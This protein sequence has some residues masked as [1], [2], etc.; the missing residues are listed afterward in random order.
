MR[1]HINVSSKQL[2]QV[3]TKIMNTPTLFINTVTC[4][5][6][7]IFLKGALSPQHFNSSMVL[8]LNSAPGNY[9][10]HSEAVT[11]RKPEQ[12]TQVY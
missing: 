9:L 12:C 5:M 4:I 7:K 2:V 6:H 1:Y 11:I 10:K 8:E 3:T